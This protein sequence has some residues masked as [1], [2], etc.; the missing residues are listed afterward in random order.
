MTATSLHL[1]IWVYCDV[2][3]REIRPYIPRILRRSIYNTVHR[4]SHPGVRATK[5]L[6]ARRFIWP[7]LNKDIAEWVYVEPRPAYHPA[8]NGM[9]ERFHR[10]LK[11][12]IRCYATIEWIDVL[13]T[14]LLGL[15]ASVKEDLKTSAAELVYGTPIRLPGEFFIDE[16]PP[17][18]PQIFIEKLRERMHAVKRP[19]DYPYEGPYEIVERLSDRVFKLNIKGEQ[20]TISTERLKP[21]YQEIILAEDTTQHTSAQQPL[22]TYPPAKKKVTFTS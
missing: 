19:L 7:N 10:S 9:V 17:E 4:L 2:S 8:S 18:D 12:A 5:E 6:I 20:V 15:R 13:P 22:K 3:T 11:S 1:A 14:V 21:V 16:D